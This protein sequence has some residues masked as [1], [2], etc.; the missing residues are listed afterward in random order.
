MILY[1]FAIV[2]RVELDYLTA[3]EAEGTPLLHK[4]HVLH[5]VILHVELFAVFMFGVEVGSMGRHVC[6]FRSWY[7]ARAMVATGFKCSFAVEV[8]IAYSPES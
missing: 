2:G 4:V 6:S 1:L 3:L 7:M 5:H 8:R